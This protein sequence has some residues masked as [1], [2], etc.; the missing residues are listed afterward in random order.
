L[1]I[2]SIY[3]AFDVM[4][5]FELKKDGILEFEQDRVVETGS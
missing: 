2:N 3:E 5:E 1:K 4:G